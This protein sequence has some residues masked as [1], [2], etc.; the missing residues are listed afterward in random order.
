MKP[1]VLVAEQ[2]VRILGQLCL[3]LHMSESSKIACKCRKIAEKGA[4]HVGC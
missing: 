3:A 4:W 2:S 1:V